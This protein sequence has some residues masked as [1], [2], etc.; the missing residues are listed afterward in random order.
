MKTTFSFPSALAFSFLAL[1]LSTASCGSGI[2]SSDSRSSAPASG[3][4]SAHPKDA[5]PRPQ[6][7]EACDACNGLWGEHGI[8]PIETCI[9][10][11]KDAGKNCMDGDQ[12]EGQCIVT[13]ETLEVTEP[14]ETP[15][16]FYVGRCSDYDTTFGCYQVAPSGTLEHGPHAAGEGLDDICVD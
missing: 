7:K 13:D 4:L 16:G 11:T 12:C 3:G 2:T 9:C 6:S 10:A 15:R 5:S 1:A 8:E 14:G